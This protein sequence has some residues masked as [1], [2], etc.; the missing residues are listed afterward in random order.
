[1]RGNLSRDVAVVGRRGKDGLPLTPSPLGSVF[2][3][4][5]GA[6]SLFKRRRRHARA[7]RARALPN[8]IGEFDDAAPDAAAEAM[9]QPF[10]GIETEREV[11][12]AV[13]DAPNQPPRPLA[14]WPK[15]KMSSE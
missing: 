12:V 13:P 8:E 9:E 10:G 15:I 4:E 14:Q 11:L 6:A 1:M 2:T 5:R 3:V 7:P